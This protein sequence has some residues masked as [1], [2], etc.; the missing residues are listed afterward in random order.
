MTEID[1]YILSDTAP[2]K[3]ERLACR[4]AEKACGLGHKVF[5]HVE[6]GDR[7]RELDELLWTFRDGSFLPHALAGD[8]GSVPIVIGHGAEP[9][10]PPYLLVNLAP[11]VPAFFTRFERVAE[12][13]SEEPA[14]RDAGRERFRFYRD[15]GYSLRTHKL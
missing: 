13:V 8:D 5:I 12:V 1:F 7:A 14:V 2:G 6:N 4:V 3:R 11:E 9:A 10:D 15:R